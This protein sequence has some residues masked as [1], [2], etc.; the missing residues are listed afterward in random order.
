MENLKHW[1]PLAAC[2]I[3]MLI[4]ES[5]LPFF[6]WGILA[7]ILVGLSAVYVIRTLFG[8]RTVTVTRYRNSSEKEKVNGH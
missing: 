3:G 5:D 6:P 4:A 2:I 1:C 8:T 7:L